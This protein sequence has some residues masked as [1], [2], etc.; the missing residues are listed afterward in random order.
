MVPTFTST[1]RVVNDMTKVDKNRQGAHFDG[2]IEDTET[3]FQRDRECKISRF[4]LNFFSFI[5]IMGTIVFFFK[6]LGGY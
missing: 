1:A 5:G 6:L 3:D 2:L 4:V